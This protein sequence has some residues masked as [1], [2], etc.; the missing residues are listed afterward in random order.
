MLDVKSDNSLFQL[1]DALIISIKWDATFDMYLSVFKNYFLKIIVTCVVAL[2][3]CLRCVL[4]LPYISSCIYLPLPTTLH[5]VPHA[6]IFFY[7]QLCIPE[8]CYIFLLMHICS[9]T[10]NFT[11]K[12]VRYNFHADLL[13]DGGRM[14]IVGWIII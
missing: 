8:V 12:R 1:S 13:E 7:Q 4:L 3:H 2:F 9:S 11:H 6:Y 10:H 14:H 5:T